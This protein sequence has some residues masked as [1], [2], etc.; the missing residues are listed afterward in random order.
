IE[1]ITYQ[2]TFA[3]PLL[4]T[5]V[6]LTWL[7][8]G[9]AADQSWLSVDETGLFHLKHHLSLYD[10][11]IT[12]YLDVGSFFLPSVN[13][14]GMIPAQSFGGWDL[15]EARVKRGQLEVGLAMPQADQY[16]LELTFPQVEQDQ[17][18]GVQ[19]SIDFEGTALELKDQQGIDLSNALLKFDQGRLSYTSRVI[20]QSDGT[21]VSPIQFGLGMEQLAFAYAIGHFGEPVFLKDTTQFDLGLAQYT[22]AADFYFS[23]PSLTLNIS[24]G[25]GAPMLVK[26]DKLVA[27]KN[28]T[29]AALSV[30]NPLEEGI[31][32]AYP[33]LN[34]RGEMASTPIEFNHQNSDLPELLSFMPNRLQFGWHYSLGQEEGPYFITDSAGIQGEAEFDLPLIFR[35]QNVHLDQVIDLD[36]EWPDLDPLTQVELKLAT[37][38]GF[39]LAVR[40]Q[41]YFLDEG[42]LRLDSLFR[43]SD[44][45]LAPAQV[46]AAGRV[47]APQVAEQLISIDPSRYRQLQ[48]ARQLE[49]RA[50][51]ETSNQGEQAVRITR[52]LRLELN[53]GLKAG[54]EL[55][56]EN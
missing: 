40:G 52:D 53:L 28:E 48:E 20:R 9:L 38:N 27:L 2:P 31:D 47:I 1:E 13:Q 46:D 33:T 14:T 8:Q 30:S 6:S 32:L 54:L 35:A 26:L 29:D 24:H 16:R 12:D 18:R 17:I 7:Q 19:W 5:E 4:D 50:S 23:E 36:L 39:P 56:S 10:T 55:N 15:D 3:L 51:L 37:Q 21:E 22:P 25:I 44:L 41:I 49:I 34:Q 11:V 43:E 45:F 42:G